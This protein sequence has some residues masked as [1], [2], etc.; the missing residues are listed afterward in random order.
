MPKK[1]T[2]ELPDDVY[3]DLVTL[4]KK[5]NRDI[6]V[7]V[8]EAIRYWILN[9][10]P[11]TTLALGIAPPRR[12]EP[13]TCP[14]CKRYVIY[15]E[16]PYA[17]LGFCLFCGEVTVTKETIE[18]YQLAVSAYEEYLRKRREQL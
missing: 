14:I 5:G 13:P 8:T 3:N 7:V 11:V 6:N 2:V 16:T 15:E 1:L 18:E 12:P 9:T 17:E 10:D 4:V